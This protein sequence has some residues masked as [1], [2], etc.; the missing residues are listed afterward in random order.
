MNTRHYD[1]AVSQYSAALSL[2]PIAP[3]GLCIKRSKSYIAKGLWDAALDDANKVCPFICR[4]G[5]FLSI[6]RHQVIE[7]DPLSPWGYERKH[8]ALHKAG[9]YENAINAFE[10]MLMK[11]PQ[12]SDLEIRGKGGNI[13]L[14]LIY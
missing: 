2:D 10:A 14:K 7:L 1:E 8:A 12:L 9:D 11:M 5:Q 13:V 6:T 3:Q 4:A